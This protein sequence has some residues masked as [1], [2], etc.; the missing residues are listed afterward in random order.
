MDTFHED[1][2]EC[3]TENLSTFAACGDVIQV[4][5]LSLGGD[6]RCGDVQNQH[7]VTV[8][9]IGIVGIA[10]LLPLSMMSSKTRRDRTD[11]AAA[12]PDAS[13]TEPILVCI[14]C[15]SQ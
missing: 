7:Q 8:D 1:A 2:S 4:I 3:G 9:A 11:L 13:L 15:L 6:H 12:K 14:I 10:A 5:W